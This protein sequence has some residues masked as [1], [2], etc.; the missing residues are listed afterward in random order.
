MQKLEC[1][2]RV[3]FSLVYFQ[4]Q[5][6]LA[7]PKH[8]LFDRDKIKSGRRCSLTGMIQSFSKH[9]LEVTSHGFGFLALLNLCQALYFTYDLR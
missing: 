7:Q 4:Y 6:D 5:K 8:S 9:N 3:A 1:F 2:Q